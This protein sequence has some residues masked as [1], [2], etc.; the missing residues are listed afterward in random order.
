MVPTKLG[1]SDLKTLEPNLYPRPYCG[2]IQ[3]LAHT[4]LDVRLNILKV[5]MSS[6]CLSA[7]F[8]PLSPLSM[9]SAK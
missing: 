4:S 9:V 6:P 2:E 8:H 3:E 5:I 1:T 7:S